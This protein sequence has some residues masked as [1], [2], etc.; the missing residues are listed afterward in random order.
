MGESMISR[1]LPDPANPAGP[2]GFLE[3]A[4]TYLGFGAAEP[5]AFFFFSS[6]IR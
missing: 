2:S 3:A 6:S 5:W 4:E 1:R